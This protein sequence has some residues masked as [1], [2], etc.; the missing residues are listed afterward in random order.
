[1]FGISFDRVV[2]D[3]FGSV[4]VQEYET[5]ILVSGINMGK[6]L[7][8]I[9][10]IWGSYKVIQAM[11]TQIK[12]NSFTFEKFFAVDVLYML[13]QVYEFKK[14]T[15]SK[16]RIRKVI[17]LLQQDT[18]LYRTTIPQDDIL[19]L[20]KLKQ[21]H[22]TLFPHQMEALSAYN[23]KVPKMNLNGFLLAADVGTGKSII[24]LGISAAVGA[25]IVIIISPKSILDN[26]W[27]AAINVEFG[28][29]VRYFAST[30]NK[31]LDNKRKYYLFHYETVGIAAEFCSQFKD[32]KTC[33]ILDES[34]NMNDM[35]S[36]RTQRFVDLC[37]NTQC[38]N[39]IFASGT[40]V[41]A[42]GYEMIPLLRCIDPYFTPL[43]EEKFKKVYGVSAKRAVDVLRHRLD[44]VSHKIPKSVVMTIAPPI[45]IDKKI[46][47]P[48]GH[49]YTV[50]YVKQEMKDFIVKRI[51]FYRNNMKHYI[52]IYEQSINFYA[53]YIGNDKEARADLEK[54]KSYIAQIRK[55]YD[56]KA[57]AAMAKFCNDFEKKKIG[58]S[59]PNGL[60]AEFKNARSVIKYVD[61]KVLGEALGNVL[62]KRRAECHS[63][64]IEH[65]DL[66]S[67]VS[68]ADKKTIC[69]SSYVDVIKTAE[70]YFRKHG[71][72]PTM[73]Y[74]ETN[75][76]VS[77]IINNFKKD[78]TI[79]PLLATVQSLSVGVTIT[80]C[81]IAIF[82]DI[83]FRFHIYEQASH[84]I[85][86]IGQDT[87]C[88][89]VNCTL[90]TGVFPNI[91]TRSQDIMEWSK[92]QVE[93]I[94]GKGMS[95]DVA[96]GIV[97]RLN[98]NPETRFE[99]VIH[100]FRDLFD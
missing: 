57:H 8:D 84:R 90:D 100:M 23:L 63:K 54:Y 60:R 94:L 26:V 59:L 10:K 4:Y 52:D 77:N 71:Y 34:H 45:T 68:D 41:K 98:M 9:A 48:D 36:L 39:V 69:F 53:G 82:L 99:K 87:Q 18:W 93:A 78:P 32:K 61:L 73:V 33:I 51:A 65:S 12:K 24:S 74:G 31:T 14:S 27:V 6:F 79:N 35:T 50:D 21:L 5:Y 72:D 17:E 28:T 75:K 96:I 88:Y 62:G 66:E 49:L 22:H 95:T 55:G 85:F 29:D 15:S 89:F 20:D 67:I 44:L 70:T 76:D 3:L 83:P 81:N 40:A 56:P 86:R 7:G 37:K 30:E 80:E 46:K 97:K 58:P 64:M 91:S 11:F 2:K 42:L 1:M 19:D 38:K 43:A 13:Q 25:E 92:E 16:Y 47:I